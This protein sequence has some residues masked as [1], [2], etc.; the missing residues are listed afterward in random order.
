MYL[1]KHKGCL[2]CGHCLFRTFLVLLPF[3]LCLFRVRALPSGL[4]DTNWVKPSSP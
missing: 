3:E 4:D 1:N 2:W